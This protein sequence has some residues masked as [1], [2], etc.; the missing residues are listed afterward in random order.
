MTHRHQHSAAAEAARTVLRIGLGVVLVAHGSQKLFGL[1]GGGGIDGTAKVMH[2][3]GFRPGRTH[4]VLAGLGEAGSGA[5]LVLGLGT[6]IAGAG[7][8]TTMGVAASI[9]VPNGFFN[10]DGGFEFPAFLGLTAATFALGG[11]GRASL[12]HATG[13]VLDRPWMRAVALVAV[14]V[15]VGIT[16][17]R[18]RQALRA[19]P[20]EA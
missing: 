18:R 8:A 17:Y 6:P 19:E 13:H 2:G 1:F 4:A 16:V 5:A 9:H 20:T 15:A 3:T 14:P 11:A 7:A 10:S 12:D